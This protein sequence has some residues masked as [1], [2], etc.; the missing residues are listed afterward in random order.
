MQKLI[1]I[2]ASGRLDDLLKKILR[3][4]LRFLIIHEYLDQWENTS[5]KYTKIE[6]S[7]NKT[8]FAFDKLYL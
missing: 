3:A 6:I 2:T 7:F 5:K 1:S 4:H 8:I